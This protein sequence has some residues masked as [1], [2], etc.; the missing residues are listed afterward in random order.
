MTAVIPIAVIPIPIPMTTDAA[1]G[2]SA[3][4][5]P[6]WLSPAFPVGAFA[7]SHGLEWAVETGDIRDRD[8]CGA[9]IY[10]LL[11]HG[12][13]RNDAIL[14][15][16]AYRAVQ[17][18]D[19]DALRGAA[20]LAAALQPTG[21]RRLE[22]TAQGNAFIAT[23]MAAWPNAGA[24]RLKRVWDG[25][26]AY[27]VAVGACAAGAE[28][29]LAATLEAFLLAFVG[30]LTSAAIRLSA[31]GQTDGQRILAALLPD[32]LRSAATAADATLDDLGG[33]V[34][35]AD[36]GSFLHETQYTRLFRS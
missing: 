13:G 30:N 36:I 1:G 32:V 17:A 18:G 6:A 28:I 15:A 8:T 29:P 20:E 35:R 31:L 27:P 22:A 5:L 23:I 12:A 24:D 11:Q 19:D 16:V 4:P 9:W 3:L 26:V 21:E 7:Y 34:L 2:G 25:D 33:A 14:L 10:D